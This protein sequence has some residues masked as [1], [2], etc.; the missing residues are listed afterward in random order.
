MENITIISTNELA[1]VVSQN[2]IPA[3]N[4]AALQAAFM[5]FF[6]QASEWRE[7]AFAIKVTNIG[8]T[9]EMGRAKQ[10]RLAL[11]D[12]RL[13]TEKTRVK[14]KEESLRTGKAID[15]M[16]NIIKALVVPIEEYLEGQEKYG[17]RMKQKA[18]AEQRDLRTCEFG[19]YIEF[20]PPNVDL[21]TISDEE[22]AKHLHMA[23][24]LW[25][26]RE[27]ETQRIEN[28]RIER[29]QREAAEREAMRLE[30]EHLRAEAEKHEAA[31]QAERE[32]RERL[33]RE[34]E[35]KIAAERAETERLRREAE[36][37]EQAE[38]ERIESEKREKAAAEKAAKEAPDKEK[39]LRY[40]DHLLQ[41]EI[42]KIESEALNQKL[43]EAKTLIRRAIQLITE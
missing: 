34:H 16:A 2:N 17:E 26:A 43:T 14:L 39:L 22:H 35:A 30:N 24:A 28:E 29:E 37:K 21:G 33:Q 20:L 6:E 31:M 7:K 5:P 36:A 42:P 27:A 13:E 18:Q 11:R 3:N 8:Q 12:I 15:G 19:K 40:A 4:A 25:D 38:R 41:V 10:A 9:A 23:K 1:N 32:E